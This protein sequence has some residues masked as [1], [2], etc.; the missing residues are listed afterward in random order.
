MRGKVHK[1]FVRSPSK[2]L[3]DNSPLLTSPPISHQNGSSESNGSV[4]HN[5]KA[6]SALLAAHNSILTITKTSRSHDKVTSKRSESMPRKAWE[7]QSDDYDIK[8]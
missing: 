3:I 6:N 8:M 4:S 5:G 1:A 7:Q 2:R